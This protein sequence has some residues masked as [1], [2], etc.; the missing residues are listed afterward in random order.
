MSVISKLFFLL[1]VLVFCQS[2]AAATIALEN[3]G[4]IDVKAL[5]V[6]NGQTIL[7]D[8][9]KITSISNTKKSSIPKGF[10]VI[11]MTGKYAIPGLIDTHVHNATYPE[12]VD[13]DKIVRKRLSQ[14]L[15]GGVTSVRDMGGDVRVLSS[16]KR[17]AEIDAIQS[18]D[19]YYS[20]IIGGEAFFSD[21]RTMSSAKGRVPGEVDWM[22]AVDSESDFNEIMLKSKGTGATGI[23]IYAKVPTELIPKLS[24]AAKYHGLKVWS[25][26]YIGPTKP[27]EAVQGGVEVVSHAADISAHVVDDFYDFRRKGKMISAQQLQDSFELKNYGPLLEAMSQNNTIIDATLSVFKEHEGQSEHRQLQNKWSNAFTRLAYENGIKISTGTDVDGSENYQYP[28]IHQEMQLLVNKIGLTPLEAI[29]S[30]TLY[31]AEVI[32]IEKDYGVLKKDKIANI[33]ILNQDPSDNIDASKDIAHVIKNGQFVYLGDDKNLPFVSAKKAGGMLWMSG[34]IGNHPSTNTLVGETIEDQIKQ[35]ME[36]IAVVLQEQD[37]SFDDVVKCTLMLDD[38]KDWVKASE[39]YKSFFKSLPT[40]SAFAATGLALG[41]KVE[42][43]CIA[44]L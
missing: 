18:P 21:P 14:L 37:L 3:I 34:Q 9:N 23:K 13:K 1:A 42:L 27:L 10:T 29:R 22:R 19:I 11:D 28:P 25:H 39:V 36:N 4:I 26:V 35:T 31:G 44:E 17:R 43:E 30:A 41:A 40:R 32:G 7:I 8:G 33:L 38:I 15:R 2:V 12:T 20:V 24:E 16:L 6:I 5:E